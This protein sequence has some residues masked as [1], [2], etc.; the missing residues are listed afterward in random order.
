[1]WS[2]RTGKRVV[3]V[4]MCGLVAASAEVDLANPSWNLRPVIFGPQ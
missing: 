3:F 1:V 4:L 2:L